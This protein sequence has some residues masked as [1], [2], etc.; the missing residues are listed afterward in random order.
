MQDNEDKGT[1]T[2]EES[3]NKKKIIKTGGGVDVCVVV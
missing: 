3:E 1:S 2:D